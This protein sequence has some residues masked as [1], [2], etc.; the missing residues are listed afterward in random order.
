VNNAI[1]ILTLTIVGFA[2]ASSVAAI[3]LDFAVEP[4]ETLPSI[5]VAFRLR[6]INTGTA[7]EALPT[8]VRLEA[9]TGAEDWHPV[10]FATSEHDECTMHLPL[11]FDTAWPSSIELAPGETRV[12]DYLPGPDSPPWLDH[13]DLLKPGTYRLRLVPWSEAVHEEPIKSNEAILTIQTPA[14][15]DA[16]AWQLISGLKHVSLERGLLADQL[17]SLFPTS[18][19]TAITPRNVPGRG[20]WNGYLNAFTEVLGKNPPAGFADAFNHAR[21]VAHIHLMD[22]AMDEFNVQKAFQHEEAARVLLEVLVGKETEA[23]LK[24]E[25]ADL[26]EQNVMTLADIEDVVNRLRTGAPAPDCERAQVKVV[27]SALVNVIT[28]AVDK[29]KKTLATAIAD[30]D[31]YDADASTTP[32]DMDAA[33]ASLEQAAGRIETA[34]KTEGLSPEEGRKALKGLAGSAELSATKAINASA[35]EPNRKQSDLDL[36]QRKLEEA[37]AIARNGDFK[38]AISRFREALHKAQGASAARGAFC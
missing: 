15:A 16:G 28:I 13:P 22:E 20:D 27:R 36:A 25:A 29:A 4:A 10:C 2:A 24:A 6:A 1:R 18:I 34:M 19:Y 37:Q 17:W 7:P 23:G 5:P 33:L 35:S 21:A 32:P 14:G 26:I 38:K 8:R 12:L 9:R 3:R 30:L 11:A 31:R